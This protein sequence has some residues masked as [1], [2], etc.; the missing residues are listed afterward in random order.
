MILSANCTQNALEVTKFNK[1]ITQNRA[2]I[3]PF[4]VI[5]GHRIWYQLKAHIQLPISD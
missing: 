3:S 1:K 5:Q 4:K 2:A